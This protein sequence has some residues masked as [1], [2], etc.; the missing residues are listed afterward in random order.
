MIFEPYMGNDPLS[1]RTKEKIPYPFDVPDNFIVKM[2]TN[3]LPKKFV[4]TETSNTFFNFI[5]SIYK[6]YDMVI[7]LSRRN[8]KE[9]FESY[10]NLRIRNKNKDNPDHPWFF[11]DI[12][13][14]LSTVL[15]N[16]ITLY[17]TVINKLSSELSIPMIYYEDL[18]GDDR[19]KSLDII[20]SWKLD[21]DNGELNESLHPKFRYRQPK[22]KDII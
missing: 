13:N 21:I 20:K 10:V 16:E 4:F 8:E 6:D 11:Q 1:S 19:N 3:Q 7:L 5:N 15:L 12:E 2:I 14:K 22:N 18:Y 9:H 17:R